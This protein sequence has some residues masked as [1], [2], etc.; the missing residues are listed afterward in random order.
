MLSS[1]L[2]IQTTGFILEVQL[3][4]V[5][6]NGGRD[7]ISLA[8]EGDRGGCKEERRSW[9]GMRIMCPCFLFAFPEAV[10]RMCGK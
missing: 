9:E 7:R 10:V 8:Q 4:L 6:F 2:A 1:G 3:G 5:G